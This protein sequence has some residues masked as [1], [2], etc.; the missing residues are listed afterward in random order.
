MQTQSA[1]LPSE[2]RYVGGLSP[3]QKQWIGFNREL[4]HDAIVLPNEASI[5]ERLEALMGMGIE[6]CR[7]FWLTVS[8]IAELAIKQA[9]DYADNCEFQAAGDLLVNPRRI[10]IYRRGCTTPVVKDRHR[11]LS[12][13][14]AQAIGS[15]NPVAWL[16]RETITHIRKA[17]LIP[18]LEQL[19]STSEMMAPRYLKTLT[20]RMHRV[21]DTIAFLHA[22][23]VD[24]CRK[25]IRRME[26]GDPADRKMISLN[27][28]R[29][30]LDYF[31][32]MGDDIENI[33][34]D[35]AGCSRFLRHLP[36][37]KMS[38]ENRE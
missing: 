15:E 34:V 7:I 20:D 30:D 31:H 4:S 24:D 35:H 1:I 11:G 23:Q 10:D 5:E 19:L 38:A 26:I 3:T 16:C 27:L 32:A 21:A 6:D 36:V 18:H 37:E 8:R 9:G 2:I 12:D 13:Q 29:F 14:F 28:C 33:I 25:L 22:W 17:P